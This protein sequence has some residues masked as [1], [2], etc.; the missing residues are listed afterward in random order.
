MGDALIDMTGERYGELVVK[1]YLGN[2]KW[3][4]LCDCG[5]TTVVSRSD[6]KAG[7]VKTCGH[8]SRFNDITGQTFG[9]WSAE[10][11]IGKRMWN[12][13]CSCGKT[14]AIS[15]YDLRKGKSKSCGH[16]TKTSKVKIG[17]HYGE[18]EVIDKGDKYGHHKCRCSC[19]T[20]KDVSNANLLKGESKSCGCISNKFID[21]TGEHYGEWTVLRFLGQYKW[22]C[23]CSCGAIK[24][25]SRYD[26]ISGKSTNCGCKKRQVL[27]L[28]GRR[29]GKLTVIDYAGNLSWNCR[30]DCGNM[31][32][33]M[34]GN[35]LANNKKSCGCLQQEKNDEILNNII[36]ALDNYIDKNKT[37]P[38]YED[39][40][41]ELKLTPVT[42]KKYAKQSNLTLKFNKRFGSRYERD[43]FNIVADILGEENILLRDKEVLNGQELDIYIPSKKLAIE[44]NGDYWH[45]IKRL[46]KVYHIVKTLKCNEKG[47]RLIHIFEHEWLN[48]DMKPKLI[49]LIKNIVLDN[50]LSGIVDIQEDKTEETL[51]FIHNN[52]IYEDENF[53]K[54]VV[55]FNKDRIIEEVLLLKTKESDKY[56][57][58][59]I[60]TKDNTLRDSINTHKLLNY[61]IDKYKPSK[62]ETK[63]ELSKYTGNELLKVG[64]VLA[65]KYLD[66]PKTHVIN[67]YTFKELTDIELEFIDNKDT[68]LIHEVC[69][70]GKLN[71]KY[72]LN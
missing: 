25:V 51:G 3:K 27:D 35:L 17:D 39:I 47:I 67:I 72:E 64:F 50:K 9:E 61:F 6:L 43:I 60:V 54:V 65:E 44:F 14:K 20:V 11:Y 58:I 55:G 29:F 40:A 38:F 1:E 19:G 12:C 7:K 69:D 32:V 48:P 41:D 70:C 56:E 53:D 18:W 33:G 59:D 63:I 5:E 46:G 24:A 52:R 22:E 16:D 36:T 34:S 66:D 21:M 30:C 15:G 28:T 45:S 57:L 26:L 68:Q 10:S 2:R 8:N 37:L 49:N 62:I 4:C 31:T 42:I 13:R 71:M 23:Q